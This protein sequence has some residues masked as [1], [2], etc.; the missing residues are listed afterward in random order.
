[1][2]DRTALGAIGYFLGGITFAV[3]LVA[4]TVVTMSLSNPSAEA[5]GLYGVTMQSR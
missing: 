4:A 5:S 3:M 2:A 1:M